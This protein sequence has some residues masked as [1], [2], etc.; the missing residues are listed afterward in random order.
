M[1]GGVEGWLRG[2][3][4][5]GWRV[6]EAHFGRRSSRAREEDE[7]STRPKASAEAEGGSRVDEPEAEGG[8]VEDDAEGGT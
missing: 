3:E 8:I 7:S 4:G 1:E 5:E 2:F 6:S